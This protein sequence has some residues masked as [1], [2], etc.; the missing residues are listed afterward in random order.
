M[1]WDF[2]MMWVRLLWIHD[3]GE[4]IVDLGFILMFIIIWVR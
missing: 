3:V 2:I 4:V 1:D